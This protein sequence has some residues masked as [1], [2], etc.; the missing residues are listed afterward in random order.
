MLKFKR[1]KVGWKSVLQYKMTRKDG[2]YKGG[3][4]AGAKILELFGDA[5]TD[6]CLRES[7][8]EGLFRA[9][10]QVDFLKPVH[11]G[12]TIQVI[13]T[14]T[15]V[16][17]TSRTLSFRARRKNEL[18]CEASGTVVIPELKKSA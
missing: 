8:Y 10:T 6:L 18:I 4:V 12:D 16:G 17:H 13:A 9:Y 7:G 1:A 2:H 11:V 5:A 14:I 3:L 15:K